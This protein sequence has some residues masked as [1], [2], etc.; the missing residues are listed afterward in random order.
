MSLNIKFYKID[1]IFDDIIETNGFH[2]RLFR[3]TTMSY[4]KHIGNLRYIYIP[5]HIGAYDIECLYCSLEI[6]LL[7]IL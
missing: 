4:H 6:I 7:N 3:T 1:S 5:T 2:G